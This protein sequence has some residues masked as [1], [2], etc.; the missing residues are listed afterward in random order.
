MSSLKVSVIE[1]ME[2]FRNSLKHMH[3]TYLIHLKV[4]FSRMMQGLFKALMVT[5]IAVGVA[6]TMVIWA[7]SL[8]D[9]LDEVSNFVSILWSNMLLE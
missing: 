3:M 4:D 7:I 5:I 6:S 8:I 9:G 2:D 1:G